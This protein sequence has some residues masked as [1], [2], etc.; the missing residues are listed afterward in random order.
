MVL[1]G[2][3]LPTTMLKF[4][5]MT[6]TTLPVLNE[7]VQ[8]IIDMLKEINADGETMEHIIREV[9]MED[10]VLRQLT[11]GADD[12]DLDYLIQERDCLREMGIL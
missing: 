4:T 9:G 6:T 3:R 1:G 8:I 12:I 2:V 5:H 7:K 10:Q 11:M